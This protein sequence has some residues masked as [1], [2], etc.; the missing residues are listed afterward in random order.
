MMKEKIFKGKK[1]ITVYRGINE[2]NSK[3]GC[4]YTLDKNVAEWFSKLG[5][6][7]GKIIEREITI[8]DVI[9]YYNGRKEQEVF[10]MNSN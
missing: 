7:E 6:S 4:S 1:I 3:E 10:L 9:F 5:G 8:E 2:Y